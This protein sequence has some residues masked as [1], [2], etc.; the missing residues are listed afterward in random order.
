[1]HGV[2]ALG[3]SVIDMLHEC[4]AARWKTYRTHIK[5]VYENTAA[6]C[7]L[8]KYI[9]DSIERTQR[10]AGFQTEMT[11]EHYPAEFLLDA[12]PIF[13]AK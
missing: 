1:M 10:V 2:P 8:R 3:N 13:V 9:V 5:F 11:A 12:M 7:N 4:V 6:R